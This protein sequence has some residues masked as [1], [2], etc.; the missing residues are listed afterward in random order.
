MNITSEVAAPISAGD[1]D[2]EAVKEITQYDYVCIRMG[3]PET[4]SPMLNDIIQRA[5]IYN[6][7]TALA[8][9]MLAGSYSTKNPASDEAIV[10]SAMVLAIELVGGPDSPHG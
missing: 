2:F 10:D 8:A 4:E 7:A 9:G 1:N 5:R 3:M 6:T